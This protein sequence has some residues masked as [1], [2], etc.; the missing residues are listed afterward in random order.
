LERKQLINLIVR[1]LDPPALIIANKAESPRLNSLPFF[2]PC[3]LAVRSKLALSSLGEKV[4]SVYKAELN[5]LSTDELHTLLSVLNNNNLDSFINKTY[6]TI[7][8]NLKEKIANE[9]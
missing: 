5:K 7:L 1:E 9:Q 6:P 4:E 3:G 8:K 2:V